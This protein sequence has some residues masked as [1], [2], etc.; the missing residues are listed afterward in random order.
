MTKV[1]FL[2]LLKRKLSK[3]QPVKP[4]IVARDRHLDDYWDNPIFF[5]F[6]RS[7]QESD[8]FVSVDKEALLK[9]LLRSQSFDVAIAKADDLIHADE[10]G[11]GMGKALNDYFEIPEN[12]SRIHS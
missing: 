6:Y 3:S 2:D 11:K 12:L 5:R 9:S 4:K 7:L 10:N 8:V 1:S